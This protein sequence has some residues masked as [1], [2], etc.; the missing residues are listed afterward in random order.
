MLQIP[1]FYL[2]SLRR[3]G[4]C[5]VGLLLVMRITLAEV[6]VTSHSAGAYQSKY[7]DTWSSHVSQTAVFQTH[8]TSR[9]FGKRRTQLFGPMRDLR[10]QGL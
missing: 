7:S 2:V 1:L 3:V 4:W 5:R 10:R 6:P 8:V 9:Q